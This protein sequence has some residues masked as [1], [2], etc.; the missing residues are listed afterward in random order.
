MTIDDLIPQFYPTKR[1]LAEAYGCCV[2]NINYW[3][4]TRIPD[5][6]QYKLQC[7]TGLPADPIGVGSGAP[8]GRRRNRYPLPD[9][10][11][12]AMAERGY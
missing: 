10:V 9:T 3:V 8:A 7:L 2:R 5:A 6:A 4:R 1:A 12:E 11:R